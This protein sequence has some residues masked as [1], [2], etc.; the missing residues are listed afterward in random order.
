MA[1]LGDIKVRDAAIERQQLAVAFLLAFLLH[2]SFATWLQI[3]SHDVQPLPMMSVIDVKLLPPA[4]IVTLEPALPDAPLPPNVMA[5]LRDAPVD[6]PAP[7]LNPDIAAK[8][9]VETAPPVITPQSLPPVSAVPPPVLNN[10][11]GSTAGQFPSV[12]N[13]K[14]YVPSQWALE[15]PLSD[16]NLRGLGLLGDVDCLRAL[17][18][19]CA[20]LRKEVF[21]EYEL[22]EMEKVWTAQRADTGMSAAFYG[23]SEREIRLKIGSHIAGE[24]GFM[25][26]PGIGI[27]GS[28]WDMLHGVK[29]TCQMKRGINSDGRYEVVR[30]CPDSLPAARDRKYYIPPKE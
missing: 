11:A 5:P 17:S 3:R 19:D 8:T 1:E 25:I 23:M 2:I 20:A 13:G 18:E 24:N 14:N 21:A 28:L 26:L 9:S 16:K 7:I 4:P 29:K 6:P 15:P 27:D 12:E 22:T 30:V 10:E